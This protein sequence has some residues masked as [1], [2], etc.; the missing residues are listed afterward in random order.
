MIHILYSSSYPLTNRTITNN[1]NVLLSTLQYSYP[2]DDS[3]APPKENVD[4]AAMLPRFDSA[5]AI[6]DCKPPADGATVTSSTLVLLE[7]L[8][9]TLSAA[10]F[11]NDEWIDTHTSNPTLSGAV[12]L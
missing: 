8:G 1:N 6:R 11:S 3:A 4:G 5:V 9:S 12:Y 10:D 2:D 7:G